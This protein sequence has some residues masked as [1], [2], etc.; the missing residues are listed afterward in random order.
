MI[1]RCC[2]DSIDVPDMYLQEVLNRISEVIEDSPYDLQFTHDGYLDIWSEHWPEVK[3]C[4]KFEL[5]YQRNRKKSR[6]QIQERNQL[7]LF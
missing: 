7:T 1:F 2:A 4:I 3:P 6:R 5:V